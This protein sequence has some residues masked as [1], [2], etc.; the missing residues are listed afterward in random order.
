VP[1]PLD[2]AGGGGCDGGIGEPSARGVAVPVSKPRKNAC[3]SC[4]VPTDRVQSRYVTTI[5]IGFLG[6]ALVDRRP[7]QN[8]PGRR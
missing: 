1:H 7:G 3:R 8:G 6:A 4:R 2:H 5:L